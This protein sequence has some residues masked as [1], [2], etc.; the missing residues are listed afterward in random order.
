[1]WGKLSDIWGRRPLLIIGNLVPLLLF[2]PLN[3]MVGQMFLS[4]FLPAT[5]VR[6]VGVAFPYAVAVAI[7]GG[8]APYLQNWIS[9]QYSAG[10]FSL[11]MGLLLVVST[12]VASILPETKA[13]DLRH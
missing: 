10:M 6:T 8:P 2:F 11:H 4:L 13:K 9:T 5:S 7:F 3:A 1:M 12:V